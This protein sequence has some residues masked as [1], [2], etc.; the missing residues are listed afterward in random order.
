M[1]K[2][3]DPGRTPPS[4]PPGL[5]RLTTLVRALVLLGVAV[6]G[7]VPLLF[8]LSPDWVRA[9][10]PE[11]ANLGDHPITLDG[12]ALALGALSS[13]PVLGAALWMMGRLWQLF[14]EYRHGRV[15]SAT[16]LVALRG[17]ARALL[18]GALLAPVQRTALGLALTWGNPPGQRMVVVSLQWSDYMGMLVGAVLLAITTVMAEAARQAHENAGFV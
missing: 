17:F 5:H 11:M 6:L 13:L 18:L 3:A 8:W 14:G 15:F 12:R 2:A 16:A 9:A 4:L 7:V 10:A 1:P